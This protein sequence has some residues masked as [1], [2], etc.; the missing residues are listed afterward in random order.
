MAAKYYLVKTISKENLE[1]ISSYMTTFG[2]NLFDTTKVVKTGREL[3]FVGNSLF[4]E[5]EEIARGIF[6]INSLHDIELDAQLEGR[7]VFIRNIYEAVAS[8]G[9]KYWLVPADEEL[10]WV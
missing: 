5:D 8:N 6:D 1:G 7:K 10:T 3:I 4:W 9:N 2:Y